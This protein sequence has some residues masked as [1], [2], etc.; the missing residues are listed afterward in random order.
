M[1]RWLS[2]AE[3]LCEGLLNELDVRLLDGAQCGG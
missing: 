1:R 2:F 3:E